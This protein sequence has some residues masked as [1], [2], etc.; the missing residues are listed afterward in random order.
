MRESALFSIYTQPSPK[1][2]ALHAHQ[3]NPLLLEC[4]GASLF[5][6]QKKLHTAGLHAWS[7]QLESMPRLVGDE[8]VLARLAKLGGAPRHFTQLVRAGFPAKQLWQTSCWLK[9][10]ARHALDLHAANIIQQHGFYED[11]ALLTLLT[12]HYECTEWRLVCSP[13]FF[14]PQEYEQLFAWLLKPAWQQIERLEAGD[15]TCEAMWLVHF[16]CAPHVISMQHC[17]QRLWVEHMLQRSIPWQSPQ[18]Y[19]GQRAQ[20]VLGYLSKQV[21][22][23]KPQPTQARY[24]WEQ[25]FLQSLA[26]VMDRFEHTLEMALRRARAQQRKKAAREGFR[27]HHYN[28]REQQRP[29][30]GLMPSM[31]VVQQALTAFG[32]TFGNATPVQVKQ[33][34]RHL[35]KTK[36]PDH[37]GSEAAFCALLKQK[38]TLEAWL[39]HKS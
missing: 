27:H 4:G 23:L 6:W 30:Q 29:G 2:D 34:F 12:R 19:I 16:A 36:H 9:E 37:G 38:E 20:G 13:W 31:A 3:P 33:A 39:A 22:V 14:S 15:S 1:Q 35:S 10:E 26:P 18:T 5:A 11:D 7:Q 21:N 8:P 24:P 17:R 25:R 32:L 28:Q